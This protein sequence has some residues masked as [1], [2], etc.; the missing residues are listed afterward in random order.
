MSRGGGMLGPTVSA[1]NIENKTRAD[2][3]YTVA[4]RNHNFLFLVWGL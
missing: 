3:K 1:E 4:I 2:R